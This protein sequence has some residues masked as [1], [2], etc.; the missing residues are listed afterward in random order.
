V[1]DELSTC[2]ICSG[3]VDLEAEGGRRGVIGIL[4]VVFCS[5][6]LTGIMDFAEQEL[7][8]YDEDYIKDKEALGEDN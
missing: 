3:P 7:F 8:G 5:T 4:E 6:C 1:D 2:T